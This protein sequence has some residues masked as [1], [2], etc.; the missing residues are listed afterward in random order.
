MKLPSGRLRILQA[1]AR[2]A[3]GVGD[4][5]DRLVLA[6]DPLVQPLFHL[7][8]LLDLALHAAG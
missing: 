7:E 6:D 2:P 3:D 1:G 4:G 5:V 8:Q